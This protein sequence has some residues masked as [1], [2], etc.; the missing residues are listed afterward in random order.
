[1]PLLKDGLSIQ[2][3]V[4]HVILRTGIQDSQRSGHRD[5]LLRIR[6]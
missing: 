2:S 6:A 3:A 1:M 5:I 4:H